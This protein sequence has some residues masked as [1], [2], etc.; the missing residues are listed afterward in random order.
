VRA[1]PQA[2][3]EHQQDG[4]RA[5]DDPERQHVDL[6]L[7]MGRDEPGV[8]AVGDAVD[9]L[10]GGHT[11]READEVAAG[12]AVGIQEGHRGQVQEDLLVGAEGLANNPYL[13]RL[14]LDVELNDVEQAACSPSRSPV[15]AGQARTE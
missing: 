4:E 1:T 10:V 5:D 2:G 6:G 12:Q 15:N 8:S 11:R 9:V 3:D 13:H 14:V 7:R